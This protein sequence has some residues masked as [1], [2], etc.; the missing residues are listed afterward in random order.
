MKY[1]HYAE[2]DT[3]PL[4]IMTKLSFAIMCFA[5]LVGASIILASLFK[6]RSQEKAAAVT[7]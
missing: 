4:N 2:I 5:L 6:A 7:G 3:E 1:K